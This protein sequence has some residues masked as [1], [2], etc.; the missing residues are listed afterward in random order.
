MTSGGGP[1][2]DL[3]GREPLVVVDHSRQRP[4]SVAASALEE[5]VSQLQR[6]DHESDA[7]EQREHGLDAHGGG[8][9]HTREQG[10][11]REKMKCDRLE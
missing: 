8:A 4:R 6:R 9:E 11:T 1:L 5:W 3:P 10:R 2:G 7:E